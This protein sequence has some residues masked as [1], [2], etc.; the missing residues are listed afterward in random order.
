LKFL[1]GGFPEITIHHDLGRPDRFAVAADGGC[2]EGV[3]DPAVVIAGEDQGGTVGDQAQRKIT[4]NYQ[5][6]IP[7]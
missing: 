2:V 5:P 6:A 3:S 1:A 4:A 7:A